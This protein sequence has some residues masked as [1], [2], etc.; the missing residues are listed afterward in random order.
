[1][2][3]E[4]FITSRELEYF[5]EKELNSQIG[6]TKDRWSITLLKELIDNSLD[7]CESIGVDPEINI[8]VE[9]GFLSLQDNGPGIPEDVIKSSLDYS[10][11]IS[12]KNLY[13]S[14]TRGQLGN[15]LKCV[16]AVP[17][18]LD[19]E[20][21]RI[22]IHSNGVAQDI[23]ISLDRIAQKPV[24]NLSSSKFHFVQNGT[25]IKIYNLLEASFQDKKDFKKTP[26]STK[27]LDLVKTFSACNC[28]ASFTL[29]LFDK[30]HTFPRS[31]GQQKWTIKDPLVSHWYN[32]D[33]F[34]KLLTGFLS[35]NKDMS[36]NAFI[37]KFHGLK[38]SAKQKEIC[39]I[40]GIISRDN[41]IQFVEDNNIDKDKI[42]RLLTVMQNYA[43][44]I[45]PIK[46]GMLSIGH[47]KACLSD[48]ITH[49][50][51]KGYTSNGLPYT[52]DICFQTDTDEGFSM[53]FCLNYSVLINGQFKYKENLMDD[54]YINYYDPIKLLIHISCPEIEFLGKGKNY[55]DLDKLIKK[56]LQGKLQI[57]C[58]EWTK[59][60]K[61][62]DREERADQRAYEEYQK[63]G[64]NKEKKAVKLSVKDAAFKVMELC[65][66]LVSENNTLPA[67]ARQIM[68]KARKMII[69]K[70]G[71]PTPWKDD[72]TFTQGYLPEFQ[73]RNPELT[74]DWLVVYDNRGHLIEP[75]GKTVPLGTLAIRDYIRSWRDIS[76]S[77]GGDISEP[78]ISM[79]RL[80]MSGPVGQYGHV[81]YIEK[82][83]FYPLFD[84]VKLRERYDIVVMSSKG[85][86]GTSAK[87]FIEQVSKKGIPILVVHDFDRNGF[88][89]AHTLANDTGRYQFDEK[90][91]VIDLGFKLEDIEGMDGEEVIYPKSLKTDPCISLRTWGATKEEA[92]YLVR[93]RK[94]GGYGQ[95]HGRRVELNEMTSK[96]FIDWLEKKFKEVGVKKV[97]PC[98]DILR[99]AYKH[100]YKTD[101]KQK[102]LDTIMPKFMKKIRR[103]IAA[104][105]IGTISIPD[106]LRSIIEEDI[107]GKTITWMSAVE[108]RVTN[109]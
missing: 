80:N 27:W 103:D 104:I 12:D 94:Y 26:L 79:P 106:D 30:T 84:T 63:S 23:E 67:G 108:K 62:L 98:N 45:K 3:R 2:N 60:K 39:K 43:R 54:N 105:D 10:V 95:W 34:I 65:Y 42:A 57:V 5:S 107:D 17:F 82:E 1:M 28:H 72:S 64:R 18:V 101:Q 9:D 25:F 55:F 58:K 70:T 20:H 96:Q 68:Y 51:S 44:I 56:D 33:N 8:V 7:A 32:L 76:I 77:D 102:M 86:G 52:L 81:L 66:N 38:T 11:R 59:Y 75:A 83:G 21:A 36:V 6:C 4:H 37:S 69:D 50:S 29:K 90:P 100:F 24:I 74:Q 41:I 46:L 71:N 109:L 85:Y 78:S 93:G 22:E 99:Q 47:L 16:Y 15:A 31:E 97:V 49:K 13:I 91:N 40:A 61:K 48:K 19:G 89:I 88:N 73:E 92:E 35:F 87:N 14:P 53:E